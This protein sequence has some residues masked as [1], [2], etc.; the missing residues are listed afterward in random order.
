M[1]EKPTPL[2]REAFA[3]LIRLSTR[4]ADND[5]YGH[6]NNVVYYA[7]FDTAVNQH[8][9]E[10]GVLDV[11]KSSVVGLVVETRCHY[12]SAVSFP[13][14]IAVGLR[15]AHLG[16]SSVQYDIGI[17]RNDEPLACAQGR[18]VHV[19]VDRATNRPTRIPEPVRTVLAK[20]VVHDAALRAA[21]S[22]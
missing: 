8:L 4:W 11:V 3:H 16:S 17:F 15:V 10:H 13:D 9:V 2:G 1:T 22:L 19:Y 14:R 5:V 12:F 20:L 7:F 21:G 18:F 6:V